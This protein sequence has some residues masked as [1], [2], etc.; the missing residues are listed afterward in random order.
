MQIILT[1]IS[2]S[3]FELIFIAIIPAILIILGIAYI[4]ISK[5]Q[6]KTLLL[7]LAML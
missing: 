4:L 7:I 1:N 3:V 5:K 6:L 2:I